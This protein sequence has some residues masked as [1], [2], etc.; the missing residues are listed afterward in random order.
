[1]RKDPE[2]GAVFEAALEPSKIDTL[3]KVTLAYIESVV[4]AFG[5]NKTHAA[6]AL[7]ISR[8]TVY[9]RLGLLKD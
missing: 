6:R 8:K 7:G 4:E 3:E 1:M 5:G 9:R 2:R